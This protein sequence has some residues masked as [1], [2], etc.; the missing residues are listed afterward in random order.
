MSFPL[1]E[2]VTLSITTTFTPGP[3]NI[4]CMTLGQN[5]GFKRAFPYILGVLIG[6]GALLI[7]VA[8]FNRLVLLYFPF[9]HLPLRILGTGYLV[10]LA[11]M[12][13]YSAFKTSDS[14]K[15]VSLIPE[16]RIFVTAVFF[17][18]V[19]PKALLFGLSIFATYV[20]PYYQDAYHMG[21]AIV[22]LLFI[23]TCS[24]MLWSGCGTILQNFIQNHKKPFNTVMAMLLLYC[25]INIA[26]H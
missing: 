15:E 6:Y 24:F 23:T 25:A 10:Y 8:T 11:G 18:F 21:L 1:V 26:L 3:N 12:I 2:F 4:M 5:V 19:N 16:N 22:Y 20:L 17:Q 9:M 14:Q 13:L 7:L